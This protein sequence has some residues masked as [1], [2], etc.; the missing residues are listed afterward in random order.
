MSDSNLRPFAQYS[1]MKIHK[2]NSWRYLGI[3]WPTYCLTSCSPVVRALVTQT[4]GPGSIH[5]MSRSESAIK[6]GKTPNDAVATYQV[7][8]NN[9]LMC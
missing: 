1:D 5:G 2:G 7:F 3:S 9:M 4:S 8:V 6:G